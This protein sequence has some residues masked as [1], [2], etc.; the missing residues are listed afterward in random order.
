[1]NHENQQG[2]SGWRG[3]G[4]SVVLIG[5][6]AII[7]FFLFTEHRAHLFGILPFLFLLA[8]PFMHFFMHGRHGTHG[9]SGEKH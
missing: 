8:C 2:N 7:G 9:G 6:L 1:M 4:R 3:S 5:F